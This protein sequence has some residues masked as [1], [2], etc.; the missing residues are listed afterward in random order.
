M[1]H[2]NSNPNEVL[3]AATLVVIRDSSPFVS[4][5]RVDDRKTA[6]NAILLTYGRIA[7]TE[8]SSIMLITLYNMLNPENVLIHQKI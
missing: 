4:M 1:R 5:V 8:L 6:G 2:S 3:Y 7:A